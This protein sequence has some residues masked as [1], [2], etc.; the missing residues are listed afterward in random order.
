LLAS[1]LGPKPL[2]D[3]LAAT[4]KPIYGGIDPM[5]IGKGERV[6]SIATD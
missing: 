6:L 3:A 5:K 1:Q 4:R 2:R